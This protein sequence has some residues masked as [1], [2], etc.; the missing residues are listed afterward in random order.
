MVERNFLILSLSSVDPSIRH[1]SEIRVCDQTVQERAMASVA[2]IS[3]LS[4][5]VET[6]IVR[7]E[8][9]GARRGLE[10]VLRVNKPA[11]IAL[12]KNPVRVRQQ[13][14]MYITRALG[15]RFVSR[16]TLFSHFLV[17]KK[18]NQTQTCQLKLLFQH[19]IENIQI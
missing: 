4:S 19:G 16:L 7:R 9:V 3:A 1:C 2:S 11:L 17:G 6:A 13:V 8:S 15:A 14:N 5:A 18:V 10:E 12:L